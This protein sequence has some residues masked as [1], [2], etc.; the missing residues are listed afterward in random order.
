MPAAE[1]TMWWRGKRGFEV[2]IHVLNVALY[3]FTRLKMY[4]CMSCVFFQNINL[5]GIIPNK[6]KVFLNILTNLS[7]FTQSIYIERR[8]KY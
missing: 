8:L 5:K 3:R 6:K 4:L 1:D 7:K 2:N